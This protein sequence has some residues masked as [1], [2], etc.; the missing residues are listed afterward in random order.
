MRYELWL[1]DS[2]GTTHLHSSDDPGELYV[3]YKDATEVYPAEDLLLTVAEKDSEVYPISV[4]WL[5]RTILRRTT[6]PE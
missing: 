5:R 4:T 6:V 2:G 1:K 3:M